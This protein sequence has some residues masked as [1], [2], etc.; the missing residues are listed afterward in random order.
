LVRARAWPVAA[1]DRTPGRSVGGAR[2]LCLSGERRGRR[3]GREARHGRPGRDDGSWCSHARRFAVGEEDLH[4]RPGA[5]D[6]AA[7]PGDD[8][9]G[10]RAIHAA[11]RRRGGRAGTARDRTGMGTLGQ[12]AGSRD[13]GTLA[14]RPRLGRRLL[15]LEMPRVE[16]RVLPWI[17]GG[18]RG[19]AAAS[20]IVLS[21][22]FSVVSYTLA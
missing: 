1:E 19:E 22:Q 16:P 6:P 2:D 17:R 5:R 18:V 14:G 7:S 21:F 12:L 3:G 10:G 4:A 11:R 13:Q 9:P 20:I 8:V 15:L